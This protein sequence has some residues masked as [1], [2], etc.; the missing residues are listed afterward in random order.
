MFF[1]V[2]EGNEENRHNIF[3]RENGV[4]NLLDASLDHIEIDHEGSSI[5]IS[6]STSTS[7]ELTCNANG[8]KFNCS[9][10][11]KRL[12]CSILHESKVSSPCLLRVIVDIRAFQKETVRTCCFYFIVVE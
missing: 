2:H 11:A 5:N 3:R 7:W 4:A 9:V 8:S 6:R 10:N 12:S 1:G